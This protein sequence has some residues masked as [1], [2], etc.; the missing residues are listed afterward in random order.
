MEN[1]KNKLNIS[2]LLDSKGNDKLLWLYVLKDIIS[3]DDNLNYNIVSKLNQCLI[4][5]ENL[6]LAIDIIDFIV[7]HGADN[8]IKSIASV[9]F[10]KNFNHILSTK[11][12]ADRETQKLVI[13]L[14]KKWEDKY[15]GKEAL[16]NF[17]YNY[18]YMLKNGLYNFFDNNIKYDTYLKYITIKEIEM[19][20]KVSINLNSEKTVFN[21][22]FSDEKIVTDKSENINHEERENIFK[23]E[24]AP[25]SFGEV[26]NSTYNLLPE[27]LNQNLD[28]NTEN[29]PFK[30]KSSNDIIN[31]DKPNINAQNNNAKSIPIKANDTENTDKNKENHKIYKSPDIYENIKENNNKNNNN[32]IVKIYNSPDINNNIKEKN[33]KV[34]RIYKP[35]DT[36]QNKK[37]KETDFNAPINEKNNKVEKIYK[38][39]DISQNKKL[40]ENDNESNNNNKNEIS[41]NINN[42]MNNINLINNN[43]SYQNNNND[44]D[45]NNN[46]GNNNFNQMNN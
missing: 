32:K 28:N 9:V 12:K 40:N 39:P 19:A 42:N 1:N 13:F 35:P 22:P 8:L 46:N 20:K 37:L 44:N 41:K 33:D 7:D 29:P 24:D 43:M 15:K 30:H 10:L 38:S 14:I 4:D 16:K 23:N 6:E 2:K 27:E 18:D 17:E 26:S 31:I 21:N 36:S 3:G 34:E 11:Y 5:N 45:L 25:P